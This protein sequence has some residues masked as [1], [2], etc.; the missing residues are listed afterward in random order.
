MNWILSMVIYYYRCNTFYYNQMQFQ[1]ACSA[2]LV[3]IECKCT[4]IILCIAIATF[5]AAVFIFPSLFA[6]VKCLDDTL[7]TYVLTSCTKSDLATFTIV[8]IIS[9]YLL[10]TRRYFKIALSRQEIVFHCVHSSLHSLCW[11]IFKLN[12]FPELCVRSLKNF[13]LDPKD[14]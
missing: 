10:E 5:I 9:Q 12:I 1:L 8:L 11:N 2:L 4:F 14:S 3:L 13:L 7:L 6:I